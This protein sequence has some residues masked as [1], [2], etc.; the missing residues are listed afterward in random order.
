M[1]KSGSSTKK[2]NDMESTDLSSK[3]AFQ[4]LR[5]VGGQ[6]STLLLVDRKQPHSNVKE[7]ATR[8]TEYLSDDE[9]IEIEITSED[10]D[11]WEE[12]TADNKEI[13]FINRLR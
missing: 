3:N 6:E 8:T 13:Y 7:L 12:R 9:Y 10:E 4:R 2:Q 1:F 5:R 11:L